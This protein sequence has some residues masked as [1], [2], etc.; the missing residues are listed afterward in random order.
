[1]SPCQY[2]GVKKLDFGVPAGDVACFLKAPD[3]G[4]VVANLVEDWVGSG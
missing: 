4:R 3:G 2:I 1:M